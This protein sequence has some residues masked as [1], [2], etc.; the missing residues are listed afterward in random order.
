MMIAVSQVHMLVEV[1]RQC[2]KDT[3]QIDKYLKTGINQTRI[4]VVAWVHVLAEDSILFFFGY[5]FITHTSITQQ[6]IIWIFG[7]SEF[8]SIH[9]LALIYYSFIHPSLVPDY[10]VNL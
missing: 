9:S 2:F 7:F 10:P 1:L 3:N 4:I 5:S 8:S 6:F